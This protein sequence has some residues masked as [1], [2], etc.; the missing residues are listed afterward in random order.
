MFRKSPHLT[1]VGAVAAAAGTDRLV[2]DNLPTDKGL[3]FSCFDA[4]CDRFFGHYKFK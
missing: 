2:S 1:K 3:Q 4:Y